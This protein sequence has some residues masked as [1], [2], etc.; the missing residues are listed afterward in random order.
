MALCERKVFLMNE[1]EWLTS[2]EP[3]PM[4]GY[5]RGKASERKLRLFAVACCRRMWHLLPDERSRKAVEM[6]E[7]RADG[8]VSESCS[9]SADAAYEAADDSGQAAEAPDADE[10]RPARHHA[11]WR[12]AHVLNEEPFFYVDGH[13]L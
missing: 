2:I 9:E 13:F 6:A 7:G 11:A 10:A 3:T 5:L 12:A 1:R 4:L 8:L